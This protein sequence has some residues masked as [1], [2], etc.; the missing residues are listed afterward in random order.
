MVNDTT[1]GHIKDH[2]DLN[3]HI[4]G[5]CEPK[6]PGGVAVSS[7]AFFD[8]Q[9]H[10]LAEEGK[11][12]A[13]GGEK[14]TNNFAEYCALGL[15][16]RW[17]LD[18]GWRGSILVQSD[19]QLVVKQVLQKWK[20]NKEHLLKLRARIW[21]L[22]TQLELDLLGNDEYEARELEESLGEF[23]PDTGEYTEP[24]VSSRCVLMWVP[25]EQ[26]TYADGLCEQTYRN[27]MTDKG[28][29]VKFVFRG[30]S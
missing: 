7:W 8:P 20:C 4:D 5:A 17:L 23:D 6:N 14:A 22:L 3:L 19:S 18:N 1:N 30:K 13:D 16:L 12:V 10:L 26:N 15:A 27:Y 24:D 11:V 2:P 28:R 9:G 29:P 25:R 21:E